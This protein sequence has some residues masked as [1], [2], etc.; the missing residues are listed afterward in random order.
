[1]KISFPNIVQKKILYFLVTHCFFH[2]TGGK[3]QVEDPVY[4]MDKFIGEGVMFKCK[5]IQ[6]HFRNLDCVHTILAH[7]ENGEKSD[8]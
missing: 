2:V 1:M 4:T 5:V 3:E 6:N 7:F 8:G